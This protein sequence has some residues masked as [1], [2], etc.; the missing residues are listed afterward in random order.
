MPI[1][2]SSPAPALDFK[3]LVASQFSSR[4]TLRQV[5]SK[6][7]IALLHEYYPLLA[8]YRPE[9]TDAD[10]LKVAT[11]TA[12]GGLVKVRPLVDVV[13][14][15]HLDHKVLDL[16]PLGIYPQ[17][18]MLDQKRFFVNPDPFA[19][20]PGDQVELQTLT[21]PLNELVLALNDYFVRP[22]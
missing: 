15:A 10:R 2:P 21:Q 19:S 9:L 1:M 13:L 5:A 6:R 7:I 11:P 12:D 22:R 4:P 17:F 14:Q 3:S 8:S 16:A 20:A 18:L